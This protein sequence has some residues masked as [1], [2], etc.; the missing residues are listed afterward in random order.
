VRGRLGTQLVCC[1]L[2]GINPLAARCVC[3]GTLGPSLT[4][5]PRHAHSATLKKKQLFGRGDPSCGLLCVTSRTLVCLKITGCP[6]P[7][8]V[9]RSVPLP[10]SLALLVNRPSVCPPVRPTRFIATWAIMAKLSL[11]RLQ[12]SI[13]RRS[14]R[15]RLSFVTG[16]HMDFAVDKL[17][18]AES[19][20]SSHSSGSI[21]LA[22]SNMVDKC[23]S[24]TELSSVSSIHPQLDSGF[25]QKL[26][27]EL[28]K[29]IYI[30]S[31][32]RWRLGYHIYYD[33][34]RGRVA[35]YKCCHKNPERA[36]LDLCQKRLDAILGRQSSLSPSDE[37]Q[38]KM[39]YGRMLSSWGPEHFMCEERYRYGDRDDDEKLVPA[40]MLVCKR[41]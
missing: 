31:W 10:F 11:S 17:D 39:W 33:G 18:S 36:D 40:L 21:R 22:T 1:R 9:F 41:M 24:T 25:L 16:S 38:I 3:A 30:Y 12:A 14:A 27:L 35:H 8:G 19:E 37:R 15:L 5:L 28:R 13:K 34:N 32:N 29:M 2:G 26:P 6:V 7:L 4:P 23:T 20:E